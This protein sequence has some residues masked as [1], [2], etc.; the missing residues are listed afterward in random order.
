MDYS[1]ELQRVLDAIDEN[2]TEKLTVTA[3]AAI[4]GFSPWH[5]CRVFR[6][7][8]SSLLQSQDSK[9]GTRCPMY[10]AQAMCP[11]GGTA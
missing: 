7:W 5:F 9:S 2:I 8:N 4:A 11:P 3:L 10:N 1:T 6:Y